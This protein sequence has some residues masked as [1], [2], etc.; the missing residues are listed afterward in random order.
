MDLH[1]YLHYFSVCLCQ[2]KGLSK[3]L[4]SVNVVKV[5]SIHLLTCPGSFMVR[6]WKRNIQR[7]DLV[8]QTGTVIKNI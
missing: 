3:V 4:T 8:N 2:V 6:L 1:F 7:K 5:T